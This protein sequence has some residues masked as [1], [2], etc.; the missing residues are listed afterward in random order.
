MRRPCCRDKARMTP[1]MPFDHET[2]RHH[3]FVVCASFVLNQ[4]QIIQ[5]FWCETVGKLK[6]EQR[7]VPTCKSQCCTPRKWEIHPTPKTSDWTKDLLC[8]TSTCTVWGNGRHTS[9]VLGEARCFFPMVNPSQLGHS[10]MHVYVELYTALSR[11]FLSTMLDQSSGNYFGICVRKKGHA[12]TASL[13][14]GSNEGV[15]DHNVAFVR[16][17]CACVCEQCMRAV[18]GHSSWS[19]MPS[20][21]NHTNCHADVASCLI[22]C[23]AR[24]CPFLFLFLIVYLGL[25]YY[26]CSSIKHN[27]Q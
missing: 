15:W 14:P 18:Y 1:R 20:I 27:I 17:Q 6:V 10:H 5:Q 2:K 21:V 8:V 26:H 22:W 9:L 19:I 25:S 12:T 24:V 13:T 3:D 4:N 11:C 16:K 23:L 7:T